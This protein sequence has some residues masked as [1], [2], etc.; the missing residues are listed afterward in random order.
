MGGARRQARQ[1]GEFG[2]KDG[3]LCL[4]SLGEAVCISVSSGEK[5]ELDQTILNNV[6]VSTSSVFSDG[7]LCRV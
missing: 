4:F 5:G 1:P 7:E 2:A 3:G 6:D